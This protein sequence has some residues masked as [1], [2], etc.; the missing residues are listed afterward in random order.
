MLKVPPWLL[1]MVPL[2]ER[3]VSAQ[4][5][6]SRCNSKIPGI[7]LS[8]L[9]VRMLISRRKITYYLVHYSCNHWTKES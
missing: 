9:G 2:L 8:D 4:A 1:D 7:V 6:I 5:P 3:A